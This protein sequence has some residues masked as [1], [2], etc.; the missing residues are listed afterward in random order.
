[1]YL[2]LTQCFP[3]R[4]GG[5]ESLVSNLALS[6]AKKKKVIVLA[7]QHHII[8]DSIYDNKYKDK[9]LIRRY[10]GFK[11]FRRRKKVS[12]LNLFIKSKK[13]ELVISDTWKSLELCVENLNLNKI[14][15]ICLAHGN[16]LLPKNE[17]KKKRIMSTL[18]KSTSIVVNSNFT[19]KLVEKLIQDKTKIKV[20]HPGANDLRSIKADVSIRIT[21]DPVLLTLSRIE[22]RKGHFIVLNAL[23]KLKDIFPNILYVIAG[24][25]DEK[26]NIVNFVKKNSLEKNVLFVGSVNENQK[27]QLFDYTSIMIMPTLDESIN[28]S[29]E[30]FGISY[31]EAAFFGIPS[32]ASNVGGTPEAV[33]H[34][35]TGIII[36]NNHQLFDE[37]KNLLLNKNK[38][39]ILGDNA[40]E[41]AEKM[42]I[43]DEVADRYLL[44]S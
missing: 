33:L 30:G 42:F 14:P 1:M 15:V 10:R 23:I 19:A 39:K 18:N 5:I 8:Y 27:K 22:K 25:G 21:G 12:D 26:P 36:E 11:Y 3:S 29:I 31:I 17:V 43:W 7:D 35:K 34:E 28:R 41:R 37:I 2:I 9:L 38:L 32:I 16:E 4:V 13:I 44:I 40:K 6:I 24:D 20:V